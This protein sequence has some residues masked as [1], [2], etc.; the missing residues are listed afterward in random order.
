MRQG[1]SFDKTAR[2]L[3]L[4]ALVSGLIALAPLWAEEQV[5]DPRMPLV[6]SKQ[7]T[8]FEDRIAWSPGV[9]RIPAL[10]EL[11]DKAARSDL[12]PY[13]AKYG[14][15]ALAMAEFARGASERFAS[16]RFESVVVETKAEMKLWGAP[17]TWDIA[18]G[19]AIGW[20]ELLKDPAGPASTAIG[21]Y[22]R[23][24]A[25]PGPIGQAAKDQRR[26]LLADAEAMLGGG[27]QSWPRF[28]LVPSKETGKIAGLYLRFGKRQPFGI[29]QF[30]SVVA[31]LPAKVLQPFLADAY[32]PLFGGDPIPFRVGNRGSFEFKVGLPLVLIGGEVPPTK[33]LTLHME[34]PEIYF[35]PDGAIEASLVYENAEPVRGAARLDPAAHPTGAAWGT[36]VFTVTFVSKDKP[37]EGTC[38]GDYVAVRPAK[39]SDGERL[40]APELQ[41][42]VPIKVNC[43][44]YDG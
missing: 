31:F 40:H 3:R 1:Q 22:L 11:L 12:A 34:A 16:D 18:L 23:R 28:V 21:D 43:G 38:R 41:L 10:V 25:L 7:L 6:T 15:S 8:N 35:A 20:T 32:A 33:T 36:R 26:Q 9:R 27:P 44:D 4:A 29:D 5:S 30:S 13:R 17:V 2:M 42:I 24:T 14:D 37:F 39:G 19:K